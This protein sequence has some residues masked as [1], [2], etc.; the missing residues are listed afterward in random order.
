M[1]RRERRRDIS[2]STHVIDTENRNLFR[3]LYPSLIE[4]LQD[5]DRQRIARHAQRR[6]KLLHLRKLLP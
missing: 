1:D 6:R 3:Y 2:R 4:R 5:P